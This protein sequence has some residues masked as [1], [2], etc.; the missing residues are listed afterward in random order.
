MSNG[1]WGNYRQNTRPAA[2]HAAGQ[3]LP[4]GFRIL[5]EMLKMK[6]KEKQIL[7]NKTEFKSSKCSKSLLL[8]S[9]D[10]GI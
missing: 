6:G 7:Q 8:P 10:R 5:I 1:A 3:D 4:T 2:P 9:K